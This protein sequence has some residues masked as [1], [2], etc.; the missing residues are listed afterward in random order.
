MGEREADA[1]LRRPPPRGAARPAASLAAVGQAIA[2]VSVQ[3]VSPDRCLYA[4]RERE[5][6]LEARIAEEKAAIEA[7]VQHIPDGW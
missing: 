4:A 6:A 1:G 2:L 5:R 3:P 7:I